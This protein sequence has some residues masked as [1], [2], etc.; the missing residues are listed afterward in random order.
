MSISK[1]IWLL[2]V[3]LLLYPVLLEAHEASSASV[4]TAVEVHSSNKSHSPQGDDVGA[5]HRKAVEAHIRRSDQQI[6]LLMRSASM[7]NIDDVLHSMDAIR[8]GDEACVQHIEH[9]RN[10]DASPNTADVSRPLPPFD[11]DAKL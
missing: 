2:Q 11:S 10:L 1:A 3:S 5:D 8:Q 6:R 9:C 7:S 4:K